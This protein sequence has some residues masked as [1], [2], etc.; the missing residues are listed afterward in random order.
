MLQKRTVFWLEH[1]FIKG[2]VLEQ[3]PKGADWS[4]DPEHYLQT[5][6]P[7]IFNL[8]VSAGT[9]PGTYPLRFRATVLACNKA[10]GV[11]QRHDVAAKG[12]LIVGRKGQDR[13]VVLE[14]DPDK[15]F[16]L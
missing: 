10:V 12:Q 2:K 6:N 3:S 9:K 14:F 16:G 7:N 8:T 5:V 13:A 15:P 1:P 4:L 11:C